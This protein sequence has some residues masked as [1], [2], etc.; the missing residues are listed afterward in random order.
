MPQKLSGF[1]KGLLSLLGSNSFG[2]NPSELGD[3]IAPTVDLAG[4]YMAQA[5]TVRST[6]VNPLVAGPNTGTLN[7]TVPVGEL[8]FLHSIDIG[9]F[10]VAAS[11]AA[12]SAAMVQD[13]VTHMLTRSV[14]AA[15]NTTLFE[16]A[17]PRVWLPSGSALRMYGAQI[18]GTPIAGLTALVS[19]LRS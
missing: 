5:Q 15:A 7:L 19:I 8:W 14:V 17:Q 18:V 16:S 6:S 3:I 10:G 11:S 13:G 9:I 2:S 12:C 1:P 4:F